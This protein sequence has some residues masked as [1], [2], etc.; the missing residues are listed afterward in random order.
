MS[1]YVI[2]CHIMLFCRMWNVL[3]PAM[4][5]VAKFTRDINPSSLSETHRIT[6]VPLMVGEVVSAM[7]N[8]MSSSTQ[9][10]TRMQA[11]FT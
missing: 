2:R 3:N 6:D 8:H 5:C 11:Y 4:F 10:M 1:I 9:K 7:L